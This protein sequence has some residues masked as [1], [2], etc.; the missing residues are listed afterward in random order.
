MRYPE[1]AIGNGQNREDMPPERGSAA[2][3]RGRALEAEQQ[4]HRL[5]PDEVVHG[6][7]VGGIDVIPSTKREMKFGVL[8][9]SITNFECS[10]A[11][12]QI[13]LSR[14]LH[15]HVIQIS[16]NQEEVELQEM[17]ATD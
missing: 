9:I 14:A 8:S 1:T 2:A 6:V 5:V 17:E 4:S 10:R 3:E 13:D 16:Q 15:D 12:R 11:I 7:L